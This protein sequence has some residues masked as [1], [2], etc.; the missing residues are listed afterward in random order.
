MRCESYTVAKRQAQ[1][2]ANRS[3]AEWVVFMDTS[4]VWNC[5]RFRASMSC[6]ASGTRVGPQ[7]SNANDE[8]RR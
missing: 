7:P 3:G 4:L 5:E 8:K 1:A 6:H 2:N